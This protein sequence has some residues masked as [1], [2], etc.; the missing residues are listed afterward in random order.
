M[1]K[2]ALVL[3]ASGG[4]GSAITERLIK[5]GW[6]VYAHYNKNKESIFSLKEKLGEEFSSDII[7]IYADLHSQESTDSLINAIEEVNAIVHA[8]GATYEGL[9][10]ET[11]DDVMNE[12]WSSHVFQPARIIR[13]FLPSMRSVRNGAIVFVSSIWGQTGASN[14]VMY[15][16]V[17]GAQ[18]S[19]VK[20]LGKELAPSKIRVNAVAPGSVETSMTHHYDDIDRNAI[21]DNIPAGRMGNPEEIAGAVL[22]LLG[23]DSSYITSQVLSINGGWYA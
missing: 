1:S 14:E 7:P 6:S 8:G 22:F 3:G 15:S 20:A 17:K 2:K 10:E 16:A 18:L 11:P 4:I 21:V 13:S 23:E 9:L 19:F 12:L 5:E